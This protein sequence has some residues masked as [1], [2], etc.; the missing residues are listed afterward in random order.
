MVKEKAETEIIRRMLSSMREVVI[1]A[2][3]ATTP[4]AE[5]NKLQT[6]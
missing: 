3:T 6:V 5:A 2:A 1:D 4:T